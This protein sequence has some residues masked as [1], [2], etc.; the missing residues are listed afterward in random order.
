MSLAIQR[1]KK[2]VVVCNFPRFSGEIWMPFLW[3]QAKTFY[4]LYG[5]H[6]NEW[7]WYPCYADVYSGEYKEQIKDLLKDSNPDVFAISL[8]VWN[9]TI[10]HEIAEWVKERWPSC[11]VISGGPHQYFKHDLNWFKEHPHL[12]ASLPGDCYGEQCF[13]EILDNYND[14]TCTVDWKQVTDIYYPNKSRMVLSNPK[15]MT[16]GQ[17]KIYP[18]DW[19]A[20]SA[21]SRH[22]LDFAKFQRKHFPDSMLLSV[23]ET[24]RGCPY[25][26]TYCDWGG[27]VSTTVLQKSLENVKRDIDALMLFDLTYIYLAD[28]NFGIFGERDVDIMEYISYQKIKT[29]QYFGVG[30]GGYAKT[31]NKLE[32][33][34]RIL[35]IDIKNNISMT[36]ELKLSMQ[37]LDSRVL[38]NIDRKNISLDRQLEVYSPLA[39]DTK[40]PL[41]VEMIMG[42]PGINLQKYYHE[43]DVLGEHHLSVQWFE[44]ILLPETP[45]YSQEYR[46]RF[47]IETII[48]KRGWAVLEQGS[49]REVVVACHSFSNQDYMQMIL[50]NSLYHLFVLGGYYKNSLAWIRKTYNVGYGKIVQDVYENF[51]DSNEVKD[52]WQAII[53]D[54]NIPCTFNVC[55]ETVYGAYYFVAKVFLDNLFANNLINYLQS[56]YKI[57]QL[58]INRE[59]DLQI[60]S[61]NYNRTI[62][63]NFHKISYKKD[64]NFQDNNVHSM[65][66]AFRTYIDAGNT[67][68][69]KK[70]L[71]GIINVDTN[72]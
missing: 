19:S 16:K 30:F 29:K 5:T 65:I 40:L 7:N 22:L 69:G 70:K 61:K 46:K 68:R 38:N 59:K 8:Y 28:A 21:Q 43:L 48:K 42:L 60:N 20:I 67:I 6:A 49:E 9:Y 13:M 63:K 17:R 34:R 1:K 62:W 2:T 10:A 23:L 50:S 18:F 72:S 26:C 11:V 12:D 27:G 64:I 71:F 56:K 52:Q 66:G 45:A 4:E 37:T 55:G 3:A 14:D 41:Y 54:P 24:T 39:V 36:K 33:I 47:G 15:T 53:D 51:F 31:E 44:W 32:Y 57:P 58:I 25:G 35:E